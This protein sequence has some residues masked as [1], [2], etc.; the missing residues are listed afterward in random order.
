MKHL[1]KFNE[2]LFDKTD[3]FGLDKRMV[4]LEIIEYL[5]KGEKE[6]ITLNVSKKT[7]DD[8]CRAIHKD[9]DNGGKYGA[10]YV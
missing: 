9:R 1:N 2:G 10:Y 5:N 4:D 7:A 8:I 3:S 6:I